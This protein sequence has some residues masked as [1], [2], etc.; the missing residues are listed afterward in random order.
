MRLV[1]HDVATITL[2]VVS[3]PWL[4][5]DVGLRYVGIYWLPLHDLVGRLNQIIQRRREAR[6]QML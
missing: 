4:L 3:L 6:R 2:V 5:V 1:L